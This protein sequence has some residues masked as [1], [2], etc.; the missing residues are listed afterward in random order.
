[1][2]SRQCQ[3]RKKADPRGRGA[4]PKPL[5]RSKDPN[6]RSPRSRGRH[7]LD[8]GR[9]DDPGP[10][11]PAV[12]GQTVRTL[13][14]RSAGEADPRGRGADI[15]RSDNLWLLLG[16]SPRSRGR[17]GDG[18]SRRLLCGPI[19]AFA[20]ETRLPRPHPLRAAADPRGRGADIQEATG[21][22]AARGRSPRS[23]G[24]PWNLPL[25]TW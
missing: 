19:L 8:I 6:G 5:A 10:M 15:P 9:V 1:M 22:R 12:A 4:D 3:I 23:R 14:L 2:P 18:I 21:N 24:R 7:A 16:R 25:G 20:G 11:I 17:R 13:A